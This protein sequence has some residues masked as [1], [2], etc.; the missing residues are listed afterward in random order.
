MTPIRESEI[1][2]D[3]I[4]SLLHEKRFEEAVALLSKR[5]GV[6][7]SNISRTTALAVGAIGILLLPMSYLLS[8]R[9]QL[10]PGLSILANTEPQPSTAQNAVLAVDGLGLKIQVKNARPSA[11]ER[12]ENVAVRHLARLH[13]TYSAWY[14]NDE[15]LMGS[16]HLKLKIDGSGNV[17]SI[18]ETSYLANASFS[19]AVMA[20]VRN[21]KF[22]K[23]VLDSAE[24][25]VPL[26]FV[27]KG[28]DPSTAVQWERNIRRTDEQEKVPI[29]LPVANNSP[30][31]KEAKH[32]AKPAPTTNDPPQ[33]E[34]IQ[35]SSLRR[36]E[37]RTEKEELGTFKTKQSIALREKPRFSSK[38]VY[39]VDR[40]TELTVLANEGDWLKVRLAAANSV[41]F[42][43]KEFLAPI[44]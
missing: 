35:A 36:Q 10:S 3:K 20:E 26:L 6:Q 39:E 8:A 33:Q 21:W 13:H 25:T 34:R 15:E 24:I 4:E 38:S 9:K 18:H 41:G 12:F 30:V 16:L 31:S 22:P 44:D 42:V 29:V 7:T 19:D 1:Q 43:R 40:D 23:G 37:P 32:A 14:Q 5:N 17:V 11:Q 28:M 2:N 27:P